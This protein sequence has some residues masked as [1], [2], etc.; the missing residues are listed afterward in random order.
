MFNGVLASL[1]PVPREFRRSADRVLR[2]MKLY[3][4]LNTVALFLLS[5]PVRANDNFFLPGDAFFPTVLTQASLASL[6]TSDPK[7]RT[8]DYSDFQLGGSFCGYAGYCRARFDCVDDAFIGNL[9]KTYREIRKRRPRELREEVQRE[10]TRLVETN[11]VRVLFYRADFPYPGGK[12][13]LRYNEKWVDEVVR[14][15][16]DRDRVHLNCLVAD[17]T[18]VEICWRDASR[19][20]GLAVNLPKVALKPTPRI[21]TP[22]VVT[23]AVKAIVISEHN[24]TDLFHSTHTSSP[25]LV[26]WPVFVVDSDGITKVYVNLETRGDLD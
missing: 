18:A 3:F 8:F 2:T 24:L 20:A 9:R 17:P 12:L 11:G 1:S 7:D 14:F 26:S 23:D 15:G 4:T 5:L 16:H 13:G 10:E 25:G 21:D 22:V 6:S 19:Y